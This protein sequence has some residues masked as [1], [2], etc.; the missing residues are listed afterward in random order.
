MESL[1]PATPSR[2]GEL[3]AVDSMAISLPKT[4]RHHCKKVNNATVGGGVL[5]SL[6]I[7]K[8][9]RRGLPVQVLRVVQ[10]AWHDSKVIREVSLR[11]R[12]PVYLMDRGFYALDL[13]G[14]WLDRQVRFIV[15]ARKTQ[16]TYKVKR[17]LGR[18]RAA[19]GLH[20]SID[21]VVRLGAPSAKAHPVVRLLHATLPSGEDLILVTDR[22]NWT[23]EAVLK[24]YNQRWH[25]ERFHRYVK[26]TIGLA[27]LYSFDQTGIEVLL[28]TALLLA[29]LL[30][31]ED[32]DQVGP[33]VDLLYSALSGLRQRSGLGTPWKRNLRAK[34][35]ATK[36]KSK[37]IKR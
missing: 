32:D 25:I 19:A 35:R 20:V 23:R 33:T 31:L 2:E 29:L 11:A 14:D 3:V 1:L 37:T 12:G 27:H 17:H 16:L 21:A 8:H 7:R 4:R 13:L 22:M 5:W 30:L 26:S 24:A 18:P 36:R 28:Y 6:G 34:T 9:Y 10:G 15:R